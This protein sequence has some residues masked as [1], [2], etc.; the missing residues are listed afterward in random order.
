MLFSS[1]AFV[2]FFPV[3]V[4]LFFATPPRWRWALLLLASYVFYGWW[5]VEYLALIVIS[6]LVD[7]AAGIMMGRHAER[8]RRRPWLLLSLATNLGLLFAFKYLGFFGDTVNALLDLFG[9][10][11]RLNV[12]ALLLPVGISFYTF[13]TLAYSIDVYRGRQEPER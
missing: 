2:V 1:L 13:Q 12:P 5:R 11:G 7:Y 4:A 9:S 6:T 8:A 3:V 10:D